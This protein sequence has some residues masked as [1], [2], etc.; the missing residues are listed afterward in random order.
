MYSKTLLFL[1]LTI[2][3]AVAFASVSFN[4]EAEALDLFDQEDDLLLFDQEDLFDQ[5][6]IIVDEELF[7]QEEESMVYLYVDEE[8]AQ[9]EEIEFV[10]IDNL[11]QGELLKMSARDF[12]SFAVGFIEGLEYSTSSKA[13]KCISDTKHTASEFLRAF[14]AISKAFKKKSS[15]MFRSGLRELGGGLFKLP[16]IYQECGV[17]KFINEI[18][19]IASRL[20]NG[21]IGAI[22]LAIHE[23]LV[24]FHNRRDL[25]HLFKAAEYDASHG[26]HRSFGMDVGKIVGILIR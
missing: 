14:S 13:K 10:D 24:I 12:G 11:L 2:L 3:S 23:G 9:Q 7:V 5:G 8:N 4:D 6:D 20:R 22:E 17:K 26:R 25:T 18:K 1:L 21:G 19:T 16:T 15:P